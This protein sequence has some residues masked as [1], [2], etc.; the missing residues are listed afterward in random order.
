MSRGKRLLFLL[1][2]LLAAAMVLSLCAGAGGIRLDALIRAL[3]EG[4]RDS[5]EARIFYYVRLPR[6]LAAALAGA[7]LSVSG[8]LLQT[9]LGNPLAAPSIIGVNAGA[10]LA[11]LICTAF[12]SGA[13]LW[14]SASAF[15]GACAAV[16][17]VYLLAGI[18]GASRTTIVLAGVA[19][20][21]L[22]SA[23]MDAIVTLVPDAVSNRSAFSIGGF[24]NVTMVQLKFAFPPVAAALIAAMLL[25]RETEILSLG[26][27]VA[28]SL[29]LRVARVRRMLLVAAAMLAGAAVSFAGL[30]SFV[31]LISPHI[32]RML[33]RDDARMRVPVCAVFGAA[34]CLLC[35]LAARTL[36][37]PYE[38]PVGILL[39]F[40]GTPFFIWLLLTQ[41]RRSRHDA[42]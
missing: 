16:F 26:D 42:A 19:V 12:V 5:V 17:A 1:L 28:H 3:L 14:T 21:G 18:T 41:K 31:G 8:L 38:L 30:V 40:L 7:A 22:L 29:G 35:D 36:F 11:A 39:S 33:C 37:S 25:R 32:A 4:D 9:A 10:G 23:C 2:A 27:E 6:M 20:S 24:S 15:A 34:L 13:S